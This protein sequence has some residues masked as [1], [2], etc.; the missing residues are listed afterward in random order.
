[1]NKKPT[2]HPN[3]PMRLE[4]RPVKATLGSRHTDKYDID[5]SG[6]D[7]ITDQVLAAEVS[8]ILELV[9]TRAFADNYNDDQ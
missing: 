5:V 4:V 1:M 9:G 8:L 7:L 2:N 6:L 3:K